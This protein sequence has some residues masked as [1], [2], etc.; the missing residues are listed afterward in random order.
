MS[1]TCLLLHC[2]TSAWQQ[3]WQASWVFY[4]EFF[5][6]IINLFLFCFLL[7]LFSLFNMWVAGP[8]N[9]PTK[10]SVVVDDVIA[11]VC[12]GAL[13]ITNSKMLISTPHPSTRW[14]FQFAW[15]TGWE[16]DLA[17]LTYII[18]LPPPPPAPLP[19]SLNQ[20][21]DGT[22]LNVHWHVTCRVLSVSLS[23]TCLKETKHNSWIFCIKN[24]F[25]SKV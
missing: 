16:G 23:A 25:P 18:H 22:D 7:L 17:S 24:L 20:Q 4:S 2:P 3:I 8:T 9:Y 10:P 15:G 1:L 21:R 12:F 5:I 19:S 11:A 14:F 6:I 13:H